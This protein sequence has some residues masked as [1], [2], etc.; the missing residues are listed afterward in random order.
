MSNEINWYGLG[1]DVSAARTS[2][3]VITIADLDYEVK[4]TKVFAGVGVELPNDIVRQTNQ[5][6]KAGGKYFKATQIPTHFATYRADTNHVFGLVGQRYTIIQNRECF[7]FFNDVVSSGYASFDQAL[8]LEHGARVIIIAKVNKEILLNANDDED[9]IS[10][11]MLLST[12][13]C[14][15][16]S[17]QVIFTDIRMYCTNMLS[18]MLRNSED[19]MYIKHT[20]SAKDRLDVSK[21]I[22]NS[23]ELYKIKFEGIMH[24][25][26][27]RTITEDELLLYVINLFC[28]P[29]EIA[30]LERVNWNTNV[31]KDISSVTKNKMF[32]VLSYI[33]NGIGQEQYVNTAMWLYNGVTSYITN[34]LEYKDGED[35]FVGIMEGVEYKL[36]QKAFGLALELTKY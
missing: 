20:K 22:I 14:G 13:H 34:K 26:I 5:V 18:V 8:C 19:R 21:K 1:V 16:Y 23:H 24:D 17:L 10:Q 7:D 30:A 11:Y 9:R 4:L 32:S 29:K 28:T 15:N 35:K 27:K 36:A 33:R 25:L 31:C 2:N 6:L 12:G 3:E